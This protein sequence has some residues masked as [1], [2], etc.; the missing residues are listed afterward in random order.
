MIENATV[1]IYVPVQT[2]SDEGTIRNTWG[3]KQVPAL[4]PIET[5]R[6][7]VQSKVLSQV[8]QQVYGISNQAADVKIMF[9]DYTENADIPNRAKV[10]SDM[11]GK[12]KYYTVR[13]MNV[14]QI[15]AE[16]LLLPVVG[17]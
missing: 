17:E 2:Q 10:E 15:H 6:A 11:D 5:F 4:A 8:E 16:Y 3:Y 14:W 13:A 9:A 1:A 12:T 7:D